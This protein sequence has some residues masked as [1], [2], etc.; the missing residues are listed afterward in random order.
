MT[1]SPV[2]DPGFLNALQAARTDYGTAMT[3]TSGYRS[4]AYNEQ[5]GGVEG[6]AH[7]R[8]MAADIACDSSRQRMLLLTALMKHFTR[9]G[10]GG[11]FIHVDTDHSKPAN[12]MWTYYSDEHVA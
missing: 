5:I 10:I 9:I 12:V 7:T 8:G 4:P 2:I 11:S 3:I 1:A 6:S